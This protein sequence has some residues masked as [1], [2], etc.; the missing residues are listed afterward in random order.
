MVN[1]I[2]SSRSVLAKFPLVN[3]SWLRSPNC[4]HCQGADPGT[5]GRRAR[6]LLWLRWERLEFLFSGSEGSDWMFLL[7]SGNLA[8]VSVFTGHGFSLV[9][10]LL[11]IF[12]KSLLFYMWILSVLPP[13]FDRLWARRRA[14]QLF[15]KLY[16]EHHYYQSIISVCAFR[17]LLKFCSKNLSQN[18]N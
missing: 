11:Y 9:P 2:M 15:G 17:W 10:S 13:T 5:A 18:A 7:E 14:S 12:S 16:I 6:S 8:S 3:S 1:K 4:T